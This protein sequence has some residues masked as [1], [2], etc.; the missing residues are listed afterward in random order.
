M[1][2]SLSDGG[3]PSASTNVT[4]G[5]ISALGSTVDFAGTGKTFKY[6]IVV[7]P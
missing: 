1:D 5:A 2:A 4:S 7:T 3:A 6:E